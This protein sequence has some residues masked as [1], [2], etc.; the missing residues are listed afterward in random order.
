[1]KY[2]TCKANINIVTSSKLDRN[3]AAVVMQT[4]FNGLDGYEKI[5]IFYL[6]IIEKF[7]IVKFS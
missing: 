5:I 3:D 7:E 1:M 6:K 2:I 4:N